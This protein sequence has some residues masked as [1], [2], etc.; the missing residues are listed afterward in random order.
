MA[1]KSQID[2]TI[3]ESIQVDEEGLKDV[4][5]IDMANLQKLGVADIPAFLSGLLDAENDREFNDSTEDYVKGYKYGKT[6]IF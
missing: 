1:E 5:V 6:G 3:V 2:R 4:K